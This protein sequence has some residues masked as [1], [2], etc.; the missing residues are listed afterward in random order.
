MRKILQDKM[1]VL[2]TQ[3]AYVVLRIGYSENDQ[4]HTPTKR[5]AAHDADARNEMWAYT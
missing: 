3:Y 2:F 4:A 5:A 1:Y